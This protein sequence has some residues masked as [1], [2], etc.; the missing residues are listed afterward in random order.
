MHLSVE[1]ANHVLEPIQHYRELDIGWW[2]ELPGGNSALARA[3][4]NTLACELVVRAYGVDPDR[5][6]SR[7]A[8][9][10]MI[11]EAALWALLR[12]SKKCGEMSE[13]PDRS[14]R[15]NAQTGEP[16]SFGEAMEQAFTWYQRGSRDA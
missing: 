8:S 14:K 7:R 5:V 3:L 6:G 4:H 13:E 16:V 2:P 11:I 9:A 12:A 1:E 10:R 15:F